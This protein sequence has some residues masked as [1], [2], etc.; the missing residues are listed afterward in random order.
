M[1]KDNSEK[2]EEEDGEKY[3]LDGNIWTKQEL[4]KT[5]YAWD[6]TAQ[7]IILELH[8]PQEL[9]TNDKKEEE[10]VWE[11]DLPED[12]VHVIIFYAAWCPHC[13]RY[14]PHFIELAKEVMSRSIAVPVKFYALSCGLYEAVC[15][16]FDINGYPTILGWKTSADENAVTLNGA[17]MPNL[18]AE[19]LGE[20]LDLPLATAP[21]E[22]ED[23]Y[24]DDEMD[25]TTKMQKKEAKKAKQLKKVK[26]EAMNA[27]KLQLSN[28]EYESTYNERYHNAFVSLIQSIKTAS[29]VIVSNHPHYQQVL[30]ALQDFLQLVDWA[31]PH[32]Q[33]KI[34]SMIIPNLL[35]TL[36]KYSSSQHNNKD[37]MDDWYKIF[38]NEIE[39]SLDKIRK[40]QDAILLGSIL[41]V[42]KRHQS[43]SLGADAPLGL[44]KMVD[45]SWTTTCTHDQPAMGYTCGLWELFHIISIG[46]TIPENQHYGVRYLILIMKHIIYCHYATTT[47]MHY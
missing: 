12:T 26:E 30:I 21:Q 18:N 43:M 16:T 1:T 14:K 44:A 28:M 34:H 31:T 2:K 22:E 32:R 37:S 3:F 29:R 38:K 23:D 33:W 39:T 24:E 40:R 36:T 46:A 27:T 47:L 6:E 42:K 5:L 13:Q 35:Q 41:P 4:D 19:L 11:I 7:S 15:S 17:N 9:V 25:E 10:D 20:Y 45:L 8:K